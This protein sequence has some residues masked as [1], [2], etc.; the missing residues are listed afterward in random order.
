MLVYN[1]DISLLAEPDELD[2]LTN[3]IV[4][5]VKKNGFVENQSTSMQTY[6]SSPRLPND[7]RKKTRVVDLHLRIPSDSFETTVSDIKRMFQ[8]DENDNKRI[9]RAST[10]SRDVTEQY[11]DA[12]ARADTLEASL[13]AL[14]ALMARSTTVKDVMEVQRELNQ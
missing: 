10:N 5:L 11:I 8:K 1:G 13:K 7:E 9:V 4:M 14:Q 12:T 3:K 2:H 6:S